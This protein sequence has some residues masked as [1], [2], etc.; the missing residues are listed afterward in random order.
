LTAGRDHSAGV[1][2]LQ[3]KGKQKAIFFIENQ[4]EIRKIARRSRKP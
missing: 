3:T 2:L 1:I 4:P